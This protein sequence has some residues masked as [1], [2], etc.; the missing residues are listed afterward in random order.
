MNYFNTPPYFINGQH[1]ITINLI[2]VGGTGSLILSRLARLH[3]AL[4]Q[5]NH[6]G[7]FVRAF[8]DD[9]VETFNVG[10][11]LFSPYDIGNY[12]AEA[13]I[14]KINQ[15][16]SLDW[17]AVNQKFLIPNQTETKNN[18][19]DTLLANIT[20]SAVD[21]VNTRNELKRLFDTIKENQIRF[22]NSPITKPYFWL[23]CGNAKTSG[24]FVFSTILND[25]ENNTELNDVIDLYGSLEKHD[26]LETQGVS[27]SY[28]ESILQQDLFINDAIALYAC[29]LLWKLFRDKRINYQGGF[30]NTDTLQTNPIKIAV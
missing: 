18:M 27:C 3:F 17:E 22:S 9:I 20:I 26:N 13:L 25:D 28:R 2:G 12:K 21:N 14:E 30:I 10:R 7:L 24:Q 29:N 16:F 5:L 6:P 19:D 8:D 15:T 11:Q 1:R 23:D 4:N